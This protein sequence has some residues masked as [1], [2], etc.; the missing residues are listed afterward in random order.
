MTMQT[1]Q[2]VLKTGFGESTETYGGTTTS[3][4]SGL[5]QG[6]GASPPGFMA[7]GSLIVNAY[8]RMGHGAKI[9]SLYS[10]RL[11]FLAAVMY[12]DNTN[13]LHWPSSNVT[14]PKELIEYFQ[15]ATTDWG[16]LSQALGGILKVGKCSVYFLD[17][18]FVN[19]H[20]RMKSL[21]DLPKP[22]GLIKLNNKLL[23]SHISIPQPDGPDARILTHDVTTASKVLGVNFTPSGN[24]FTHVESMVQK[25]L[26]WVDCLHTK[27]LSRRDA[28]LRFYFQLFPGMSW[29]LVTVCLQPKKQDA[30][31]QRICEGTAIPGSKS[32]H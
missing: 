29:G 23:P 17:Y 19:G 26:D 1:M 6:S 32:K 3:P 14:D 9:L 18:K 10:S 2:Y 21:G 25:G 7:L 5:G 31:I 12:V 11:F 20:A 8:R 15:H 16:K 13:L 22:T 27:P 24:S 28:W 30:M 4:N